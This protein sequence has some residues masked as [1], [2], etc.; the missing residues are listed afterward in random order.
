MSL[1]NFGRKRRDRK[2]PFTPPSVKVNPHSV[3]QCEGLGT[4]LSTPK[5]VGFQFIVNFDADDKE[6]LKINKVILDDSAPDNPKLKPKSID[7]Q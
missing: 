5:L 7:D 4:H 3:Y 6:N 1:G 2:N